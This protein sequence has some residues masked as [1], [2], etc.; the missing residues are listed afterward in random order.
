MA[1]KILSGKMV[2]TTAGEA[3]ALGSESIQGAL[4]VR[5]LE[6]NTGVVALGNDGAGDVSVVNGLRLA[7]G[8]A[9]RFEFV[10]SLGALRLDAAV[11]GEGV[12]WLALDV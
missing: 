4:L 7:A 12:S 9:V 5:A 2:V 11:S 10:G 1:G 8:E 3:V 6:T